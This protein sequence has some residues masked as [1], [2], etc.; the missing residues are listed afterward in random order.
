MSPPAVSLF[1]VRR[2]KRKEKKRKREV[3]WIFKIFLAGANCVSRAAGL[4]T[5]PR[6]SL[7]PRSIKDALHVCAV[8][9]SPLTSA[10]HLYSYHRTRKSEAAAS[11]STP[12]LLILH[13]FITLSSHPP[14]ATPSPYQHS[15]ARHDKRLAIMMQ[16]IIRVLGM[17]KGQR[18]LWAWA[19]AAG[20]NATR[21]VWLCPI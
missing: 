7:S 13:P 9:C 2:E 11:P 10:Q 1:K 4:E 15:A 8:R 19:S 14:T 17:Q 3:L 6:P 12:A 21:V 16:P 5:L 20:A 18:S